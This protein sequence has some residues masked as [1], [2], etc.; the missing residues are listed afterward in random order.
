MACNKSTSL[1]AE[2]FNFAVLVVLERIGG[3][4]RIF[5]DCSS[6]ATT[7]HDYKF[8]CNLRLSVGGSNILRII[9]SSFIVLAYSLPM[10]FT[11]MSSSGKGGSNNKQC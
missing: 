1:G 2:E 9:Y 11:F 3:Y 7:L 5:T 10:P 8:C 6:V 4:F